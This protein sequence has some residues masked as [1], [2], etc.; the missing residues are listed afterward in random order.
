MLLLGKELDEGQYFVTL[1][2]LMRLWTPMNIANEISKFI[3]NEIPVIIISK[4]VTYVL[5]NFAR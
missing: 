2:M 5:Y 3:G 1:F 4:S